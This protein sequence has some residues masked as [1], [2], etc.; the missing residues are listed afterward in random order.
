MDIEAEKKIGDLKLINDSTV[1][2]IHVVGKVDPFFEKVKAE[3]LIIGP[4]RYNELKM[5]F[6][7]GD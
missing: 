3:P 6:R 5:F 7:R 1:V 2:F 4:I